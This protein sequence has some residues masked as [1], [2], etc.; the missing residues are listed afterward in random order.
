[1]LGFLIKGLILL[2][3]VRLVARSLRGLLA[4]GAS[5]ANRRRGPEP[6]ERGD[7]TVEDDKPE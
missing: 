1:M 5:P 4:G 2:L 7:Y 3:V 6:P